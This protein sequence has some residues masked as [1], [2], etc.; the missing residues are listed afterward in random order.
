MSFRDPRSEIYELVSTFDPD[1]TVEDKPIDEFLITF[2]TLR[3][4]ALDAG[5]A[6]PV[7]LSA[8]HEAALEIVALE[9]LQAHACG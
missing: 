1:W 7:V 4:E 6:P 5:V 3:R 2:A 8:T 9:D